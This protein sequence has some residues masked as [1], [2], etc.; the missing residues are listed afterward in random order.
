V[1]VFRLG[2]SNPDVKTYLTENIHYDLDPGALMG[3]RI[4][5]DMPK[6]AAPAPCAATAF[7]D[8]AKTGYLILIHD[9]HPICVERVPFRRECQYI[10]SS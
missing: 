3:Y 2:L 8:V 1:G 10:F 5:I 7:L 6:S 9:V 4:S